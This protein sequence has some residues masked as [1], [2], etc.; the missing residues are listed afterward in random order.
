MEKKITIHKKQKKKIEFTTQFVE[1][2][3][4][5]CLKMNLKCDDTECETI[6]LRH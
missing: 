4:F 2:L 6:P 1:K 5:K 3:N